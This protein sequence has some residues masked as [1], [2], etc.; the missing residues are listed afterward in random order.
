MLTTLKRIVQEVNQI[1]VLEDALQCLANRLRT[2]LKVDSCSIYLADYEKQHFL[3][4]ATE[5]LAADA[6]GK[7]AIGFSEGLIGLIG[8]REEPLN[9][10][11]ARAHPRF[12]HYPEVKEEKYHAFLGAPIIHQRKVLG[13]LTLQQRGKRRFSEDEEAF[14]VT[15]AAQLALEIKHAEARGL[16]T[17]NDPTT[18][19]SSRQWQKTLRGVP[20]ATGLGMGVG[21]VPGY[22]VSL[23]NHVPRRSLAVDSEIQRYRSAVYA[24]RSQVDELSARIEG[25]VPSDVLAIFQIYHHLLDANSLGHEVEAR[26]REG[27]D[28]ASG[29][30]YV[31]DAYIQRFR[32]MSDPYMQERAVDMEDLS[33]RILANILQPD[34]GAVTPTMPEGDVILVAEEVSAPMLAEFPKDRVRGIVSMRGSN[35]SHAAILARAMGVPAVMGLTDVPLSML[36]GRQVLLDGYS[37]EVIVSPSDAIQREFRVLVDEEMELS[38]RIQAQAELPTISTDNCALDLYIN[39]GLS[40]ELESDHF[41]QGDGVGLYRT[42]VPFMMRERFPSEQ[43]QHD[44]Y[45]A[46][47]SVSPDKQITM[48]TLD[49]GGDKPLPYFP[50]N[51]EN[52]FL[53]WRGIRLTLDHPEIFLVQ[54]R[55]MLRASLGLENL[56]VMLPM[57]TSVSEVKEAKRLI[58]QAFHEVTEECRGTDNRVVMPKVGVM[59]EVPA[60]VYQ[61]DKLA[62]IVDFFSV[63]SNDLTQ[64][65]L[66]VD[67]N[68]ARV[69]GLYDSYHPAVLMALQHIVDEAQRL[70]V[71]VT[72]CGEM[73]GEPGGAILLMAMGYRRLSMNSHNL[74]KVKWVIRSVALADTH[75]LLE[76]VMHY[77]HPAA[78]REA[79]NAYLES[80]GL[81][82]LVRAGS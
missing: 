14:L 58:R 67:R 25:E 32:D 78:V 65:L 31:V 33:N 46:M 39:A 56:Q 44:L 76:R 13:V 55:A 7:V 79:V 5:G 23:N 49:V 27:W 72:V 1:P 45:R 43:E 38:D 37:G 36:D 63:G 70:N 28:A 82:G 64:Y 35:N 9:I 41:N 48:R 47:L 21:F 66:A 75:Q 73:A 11:D 26:I 3:L 19:S 15:L 6:V 22:K 20:G 80:V 40:A 61:L 54:V 42:E 18:A 53:G 29:L 34:K 24:T 69:A 74:L 4:M 17:L 30:K 57:I 12:K 52:P 59:I 51:E 77:E 50:I 81:G 2:A 62:P 10:S 71:P 68:N 8:Q 16:M 60:L